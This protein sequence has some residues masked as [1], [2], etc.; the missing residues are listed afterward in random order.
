MMAKT[1]SKKG[2][3][4]LDEKENETFSSKSIDDVLI[5]VKR[6][7]AALVKRILLRD[8]TNGKMYLYSKNAQSSNYVRT[9]VEYST[10]A[11]KEDFIFIVGADGKTLGSFN[12]H[13]IAND[14]IISD[15][16][17]NVPE[18]ILKDTNRKKAFQYKITPGKQ[19]YIHIEIAYSDPQ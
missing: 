4:I 16:K 18:F 7:Q 11:S 6:Q 12:N 17:G 9:E 10:P 1:R 3:V 13:I 19:N 14:Y 8:D 15:L 5:E 2:Y